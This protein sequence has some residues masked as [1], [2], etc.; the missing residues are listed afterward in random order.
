MYNVLVYGCNGK[1]IRRPLFKYI[2]DGQS[3]LG[4]YD[5]HH[6]TMAGSNEC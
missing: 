3:L 2:S 1:K 5:K 6:K 4:A